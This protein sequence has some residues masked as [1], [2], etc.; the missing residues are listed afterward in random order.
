MRTER[1]LYADIVMD[2]TT[3]NSER[4]D[5]YYMHCTTLIVDHISLKIEQACTLIYDLL[6]Y[7]LLFVRCLYNKITS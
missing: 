3:R 2:I 6:F 4:K 5:T 7:F 1:R